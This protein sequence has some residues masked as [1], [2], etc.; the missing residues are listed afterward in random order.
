MRSEAS[1]PERVS[2]ASLSCNSCKKIDSREKIN[3]SRPLHLDFTCTRA[4]YSEAKLGT[5][6]VAL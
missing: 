5:L 1:T 2:H 4:S 3:I 6:L